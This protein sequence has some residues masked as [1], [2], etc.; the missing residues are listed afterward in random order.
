MRGYSLAEVLL[1]LGLASVLA[2]TMM[3]LGLTAMA[4]GQKALDLSLAARLAHD[5]LQEQIYQAQSD[6][7]SGFWTQNDDVVPFSQFNS[8]VGQQDY[9]VALYVSDASA[10]TNLKRCRLRV[11]WWGGNSRQGY[12]SLNTQAVRF[13]SRP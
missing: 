5:L 1:A 8:K 6:S 2:L 10:N 3:G 4:G 13:V 11:N 7:A 9:L 12:G